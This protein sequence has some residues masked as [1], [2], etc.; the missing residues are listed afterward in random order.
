MKGQEPQFLTSGLQRLGEFHPD[1]IGHHYS[2]G[3]LPSV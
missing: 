3:D 2:R 1:V